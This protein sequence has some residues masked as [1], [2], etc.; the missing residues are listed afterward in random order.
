MTGAIGSLSVHADQIPGLFRQMAGLAGENEFFRSVLD[1]LPAAI[2]ITDAAGRIT[3]YNEAAAALWGHRPELGDSEWFGS[4]KL[5]WPDGRP[6]PHDQCPMAVA[7]AQRRPIR[8]VEAVGERPDGS[9]VPFLPFPTPFFDASGVLVGAVNMLLDLSDRKRAD[10]Y[11]RRLAAIVEG[12][13]D[14]IVSKDL[15]GSVTSWNRGAEQLFGYTAAE[16]IGKSI[17]LLIP[18]DRRDEETSILERI[19]RGEHIDHYETVRSRRD[20]SLVEVSLTVSPVRDA[21]GRIVGAS[22][23]V[24]DITVQQRAREQQRILFNEMKH[25]VRNT[26]ATVQAIAAQTFPSATAA[27]RD[28]FMARLRALANAHNLLTLETSNRARL[29]DVVAETLEPFCE[30][31]RERFVLDGPDDVWLSASRSILVTLALHELATNAAKY[32]ALSNREGRVHVAWQLQ[33]DPASPGVKLQWQERGGPP[34]A[35]PQRKG[36]GSLL[37]ERVLESEHGRAALDFDP[38]GLICRLDLAL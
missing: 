38:Q 11:E 29:R 7:L 23:I 12:S 24:R 13:D 9:R 2:Y 1:V 5:F 17:T 18:E 14:A 16:I 34:V 6:L 33:P 26:L 10:E 30:E 32:G 19:R 27:E 31:Q 21:E 35:P 20:G 3:Y 37:I 8:G 15:D 4:W 22:K 25:R 36:F 28:A